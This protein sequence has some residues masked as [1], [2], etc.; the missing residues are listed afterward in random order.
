MVTKVKGGVRRKGELSPPKSVRQRAR[1]KPDEVTHEATEAR[2]EVQRVSTLKESFAQKKFTKVSFKRFE[3]M[4]SKVL[5][6]SSNA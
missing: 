1:M 4:S 6:V 3:D 5:R 2:I